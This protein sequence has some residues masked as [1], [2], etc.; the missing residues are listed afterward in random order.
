MLRLGSA[1]GGLGLLELGQY[2]GRVDA[3]EGIALTYLL[4]LLDEE[5]TDA[6]GHLARDTYLLDLDLP[7]DD[8]LGL[9]EE[10]IARG[11]QQKHG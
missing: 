1:L 11:S 9:A 10:D 4:P 7:G 3:Y 8:V 2:L 6:S 5:F